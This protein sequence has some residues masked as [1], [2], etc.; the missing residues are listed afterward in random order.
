MEDDSM[1]ADIGLK[2]EAFLFEVAQLRGGVP[3]TRRKSSLAAGDF[4][5]FRVIEDSAPTPSVR[6]A[7]MLQGMYL[8]DLP[9]PSEG[10]STEKDPV[11]RVY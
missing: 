5:Y 2:K 10:E 11:C 3:T 4:I 7:G 9:D 8:G 6:L 1:V